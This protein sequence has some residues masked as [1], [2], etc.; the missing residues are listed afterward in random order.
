MTQSK[1]WF[2]AG[3]L[4]LAL[5]LCGGFLL[6]QYSHVQLF[7]EALEEL[8]EQGT[9]GRYQ[10]EIGATTNHYFDFSFSFRDI[11]IVSSDTSKSGIMEVMIPNLRVEIGSLIKMFSS[12]QFRIKR[13]EVDEPIAI[14]GLSAAERPRE[15]LHNERVNLAHQIAQFYPAVKTVLE[16]FDI[17][18]FKI[19]RAGLRLE[20][21]D[22]IIRVRLLDLL[23]SDWNMRHLADEA[24]FHLSLGNQSLNLFNASFSFG[25][26][27]YDYQS[28]ELDI[29]DYSYSK[30]DSLE[31]E[32]VTATGDSLRIVDL[33]YNQ[34]VSTEFYELDRLLLANPA[35]TLHIYPERAR[36]HKR[37]HPIA[38]LVKESLGDLHIRDVEILDAKLDL[39]LHR[40]EDTL[41]VHLP[42]LNLLID[43]LEITHDSSTMVFDNLHLDV[44]ESVLAIN[45]N[46][47]LKFANL[48]YDENSRVR[49]DSLQ[50][51][52]R[53]S[54][55]QIIWCQQLDLLGF[56]AFHMFYEKELVLDSLLIQKG[57]VD[58]TQAVNLNPK[59][60]TSHRSRPAEKLNIAYTQFDDF[61]A[62]FKSGNKSLQVKNLQ[63]VI[64]N[65]SKE[66]QTSFQ[67]RYLRSPEINFVD[68][69]SVE[70]SV[71]QLLFE[72]A[73]L[74]FATMTGSY[75]DLKFQLED[76][77]AVPEGIIS[78]DQLT[79]DWNTLNI[80][81]LYLEGK[82]PRKTASD[83]TQGDVLSNLK[84]GTLS[85]GNV[86]AN[87][88]L[89]DSTRLNTEVSDF[90][91]N[92]LEI[93]EGQP[94]WDK[95]SMKLE[96][97]DFRNGDLICKINSAIIDN[98]STSVLND[99]DL[100]KGN[101]NQVTSHRVEVGPWQ[102][103]DQGYRIESVMLG[104]LQ[105]MNLRHHTSSTFDSLKLLDIQLPLEGLPSARQI[106]VYAPEIALPDKTEDNSNETA[107]KKQTEWSPR[108]MLQQL[109][110]YPGKLTRGA[111]Q[112]SFGAISIDLTTNQ[113]KIDLATLS[114]KTA[115]SSIHVGRIWSRQDQLNIDSIYLVP[116]PEY[117]ASIEAET[118]ILS[119][120]LNNV[121]LDN[122]DW[123]QLLEDQKLLASDLVITGFDL[124]IKRD[125]TLPDPIHIDK[126]YLLS[127]FIPVS[128]GVEIAKIKGL[129]GRLTYIEVGENTGQEGF[130]AVDDISFTMNRNHPL[131]Q[132]EHVSYGSALIYGKGPI[133]YDYHRLDSG[134]F[135]LMVRLKDM[136]L[137][138]LNQ[139]VDPL[140]A[141]KFTS[142]YLHQFEMNLTGD[143]LQ[144]KGIGTITYDDLHVEIFKSHQP[145][146]KN[147]GSGL[148]TLL[149]DKLIL[150]HSKYQASSEFEQDRITFKGP[151][152]Y[153]VKSGI[154]AA[155]AAVMKGKT[156]KK[157]KRKSDL[158]NP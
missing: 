74:T 49:V 102:Q 94:T 54:E 110:V 114:F 17:S 53:N 2:Y 109:R 64:E 123:D 141:A 71:K 154:H 130:I 48:A 76:F 70:F 12:R 158:P 146:V 33:D 135:S 52:D 36:R 55:S 72:P 136:P 82:I 104:D 39:S 41:I 42:R 100:T 95:T 11:H 89:T 93:S 25:S 67:L 63:G 107:D 8:V 99:L 45:Q 46:L 20:K 85:L 117:V 155:G 156:Q 149:V 23:V 140:E 40:E 137:E 57:M 152:N 115:K 96:Q 121:R 145:D 131:S 113:P 79:N 73:E 6:I 98:E 27:V 1:K 10:L 124:S 68:P 19:E 62:A 119:A 144:A 87:I 88:L 86:R 126:P 59:T 61:E 128:T 120:Q 29:L 34:L 105:W 134:K 81:K 18:F 31:R 138:L 24:S 157:A 77:L 9:G 32:L 92:T 37:A 3:I 80:D 16:Q 153:W 83:K 50:V 150:K 143:S 69:G 75:R 116:L 38:D 60:S 28:N 97:V 127:E 30:W 133:E 125:K 132:P 90:L 15:R 122:L 35:V 118:D 148:L 103:G 4:I 101:S 84:L 66:G 14:I 147:F 129:D 58:L 108:E 47:G 26:I 56:N 91:V 106:S 5:L 51:I 13:F 44:H 7:K 22:G 112:L 65:L 151:I 111:Q 139:M 142:G 21:T 43:D 78:T